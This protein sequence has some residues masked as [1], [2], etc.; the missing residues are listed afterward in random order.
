GGYGTFGISHSFP[1]GDKASLDFSGSVGWDFGY[2]NKD[3]S[4]GTLN[5]ALFGVNVPITFNDHFSIHASV[6]KSIALKSLD[7][8]RKA[9][10]SLTGTSEDETVF[11]FGGSISF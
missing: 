4:N 7:D 9:D 3:E 10:P 5:D 8:R 1:L 6:Q 11:T 2:N